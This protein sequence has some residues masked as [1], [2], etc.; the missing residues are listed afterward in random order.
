MSDRPNTSEEKP[1]KTSTKKAFGSWKAPR[2]E[3]PSGDTTRS[4]A[5]RR[6]RSASTAAAAYH[7]HHTV[8]EM[9]DLQVDSETPPWLWVWYCKTRSCHCSC[10][11]PR[12]LVFVSLNRP[13]PR[14][15]PAR[16]Y[17]FESGLAAGSW[18]GERQ[19]KSGVRQA[20]AKRHAATVSISFV[21]IHLSTLPELLVRGRLSP[22]TLYPVHT[23]GCLSCSR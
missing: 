6:V 7:H 15:L 11:K 22:T 10:P 12:Q 17:T 19:S 16:F 20:S 1:V 5:G 3:V 4:Q 8:I 18:Q 2:K 9:R 21:A 14:P 13:R 23:A